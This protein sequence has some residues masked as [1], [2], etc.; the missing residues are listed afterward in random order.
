MELA[1]RC[2]RHGV[3][4]RTLTLKVK[5]ADFE[6]I[7]RSVSDA[8]GFVSEDKMRD[9]AAELAR[10]VDTSGRGIRLLG[11]TTSN[12]ISEKEEPETGDQL[13]LF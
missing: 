4:G 5:F 10:T 13:R 6:Q 1:G 12:F 7:T 11:L 8:D 3:V 2:G 9:A